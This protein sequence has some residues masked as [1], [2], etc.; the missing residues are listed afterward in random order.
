M[1][2]LRGAKGNIIIDLAFE[3]HYMDVRVRTYGKKFQ[4]RS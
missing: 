1:F 4:D 3:G 2:S